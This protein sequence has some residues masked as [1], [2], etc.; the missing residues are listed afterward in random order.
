MVDQVDHEIKL[1]KN[2]T[3]P[4]RRALNTMGMV[5]LPVL[6]NASWKMHLYDKRALM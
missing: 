5:K 3:I 1:T 2:V 4:P 6:V